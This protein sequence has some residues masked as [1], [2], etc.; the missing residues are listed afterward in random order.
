MVIF[1]SYVSL[2]EGRGSE[3]MYVLQ[4][5]GVKTFSTPKF[6]VMVMIGRLTCQCCLQTMDKFVHPQ[7]LM[8]I[9]PLY[10]DYAWCNPRN[11][12]DKSES[13]SHCVC[14]YKIAC[15]KR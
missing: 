1:H 8:I 12:V 6:Q 5:N 9:C 10:L 13:V 2:Q 7:V 14:A 15:C 3:N 4:E 11:P